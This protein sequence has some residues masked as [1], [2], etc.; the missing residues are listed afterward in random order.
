MHF[1]YKLP[2][3]FVFFSFILSLYAYFFNAD[4]LIIAGCFAWFALILF[5]KKLPNKIIITVLL[6]LSSVIYIF[7]LVKGYNIDYNKMLTTNQYL[8]SLLIG[9]GFLR[10]VAVPKAVEETLPKGKKAWLQTYLNVHLLSS[11]INLSGLILVADKLYRHSK[12]SRTQIILLTRAFSTDAYWSPFFVSFGAAL[13]YLPNLDAHIIF[14]NGIILSV[15]AFILTYIESRKDTTLKIEHF[16]GYPLTLNSLAFPLLLGI[17]VLFMKYYSPQ[18]STI[19]LIAL[20]SF[21]IVAF[22]LPIKVGFR[23]AFKKLTT[24]IVDDL[25]KMKSELSLF[26]TAGMFGFLVAILVRGLGIDISFIYFNWVDASFLLAILILLGFIGIHPL[27]SIAILGDFLAEVN[28][29]LFAVMF[30]MAWS[31]TVASSIFSGLNLTIA[32][33]YNINAKDIFSLNFIYVIKMYFIGVLSLYIISK[34]YT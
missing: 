9:V 27:I 29:T 34:Y 2:G 10:L 12:L 17:C 20:C 33:R 1:Y 15:I 8:L 16:L 11:V 13:S 18:T 4:F 28:H 30:L 31:I 32:A 19:M 7:S 5:Y 22:I 26:V 3:L 24:H 23:E 25:P 14:A 6:S 21:F